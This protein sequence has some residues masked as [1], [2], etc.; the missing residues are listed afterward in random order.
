MREGTNKRVQKFITNLKNAVAK[1]K[2]EKKKA[3]VVE[4]PKVEETKFEEVAPIEAPTEAPKD[5]E[6]KAETPKDEEPKAEAPKDEEPKTEE[7]KSEEPKAEEPKND[8]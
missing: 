2:E 7:P 8:E 5:E 1:A 4:T 3:A 6:P